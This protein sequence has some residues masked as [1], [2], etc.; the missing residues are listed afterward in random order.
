MNLKDKIQQM[1]GDTEVIYAAISDH[2]SVTD[3]QGVKRPLPG[4]VARS[5]AKHVLVN[6]KRLDLLINGMEAR[7]NEGTAAEE[8]K[9]GLAELELSVL[10]GLDVVKVD[11]PA[12]S[13]M[14][15]IV[16]QGRITVRRVRLQ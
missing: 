10:C 2:Y 5:T 14:W 8:P 1:L 6:L 12:Y 15:R 16:G 11:F 13:T 7:P 9:P 4:S 3:E